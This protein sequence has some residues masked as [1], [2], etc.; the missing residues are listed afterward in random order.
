MGPDSR[1]PT[2]DSRLA[3]PDSRLATRD[4]RLRTRDSGLATPDSRLRTRDSGLVTPDS[5]LPT[6]PKSRSSVKSLF[7][8]A[9]T[10][11]LRL[12]A[13]LAS[14]R[15]A[16]SEKNKGKRSHANPRLPDSRLETRSSRL[17]TPDSSDVMRSDSVPVGRPADFQG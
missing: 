15:N 11:C 4:S 1:P 2:R 13:Y 5:L 6:L 7:G 8:K 10:T 3:T 14:L 12:G 9:L 16:S 17:Q